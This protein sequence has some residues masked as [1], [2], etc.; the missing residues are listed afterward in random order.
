MTEEEI[1]QLKAEKSALEQK[2]SELEGT[3]TEK[4]KVIEE[5][6]R[7]II[8]V[9]KKYSGP[10]YKKFDELTDEEKQ[11]MSEQDIQRKKEQDILFDQQEEDRQARET[12]RQRQIN[13]RKEAAI[14][15]YAGDNEEIANKIRENFDRIKDSDAAFTESEISTF[16]QTAYNMLGD[17]RPDPVRQFGIDDN[18]IAPV[19]GQQDSSF[20]DTPEGKQVASGMGL[21]FANAE[22]NK[23]QS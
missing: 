16:A 18:A 12:D 15:K 11:N 17:E 6:N 5:K 8:G 19:Y 2:V 13:E 20:G 14:R 22:E 23:Q 21:G 9:R 10:K 1:N 7:D 3:I 4:D